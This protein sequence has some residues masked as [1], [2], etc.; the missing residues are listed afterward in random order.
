VTFDANCVQWRKS[1]DEPTKKSLEGFS[2]KTVTVRRSGDDVA[3]DLV[4]RGQPNWRVQADLKGSL[5]VEHIYPPQAV[6]VGEEWDASD[7]AA[8]W[9]NF[10]PDDEARVTC[11]LKAVREEKGRKV[12]DVT[13]DASIVQ[14][15]KPDP[16]NGKSDI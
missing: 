15:G 10:G 4:W 13:I 11:M 2:G 14:H 12:A 8:H 5:G 9:V 1:G 3:H 7:L 6:S 16:D